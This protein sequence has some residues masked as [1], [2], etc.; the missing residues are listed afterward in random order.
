MYS[1]YALKVIQALG[2]MSVLEN[3]SLIGLVDS[4]HDA[5]SMQEAMNQIKEQFSDIFVGNYVYY[6]DGDLI[7]YC[8]IQYGFTH[9]RKLARQHL[10]YL[11]VYTVDNVEVYSSKSNVFLKEI[12]GVPFNTVL[13]EG[14]KVDTDR[15]E[16]LRMEQSE[17]P[18]V[19]PFNTNKEFVK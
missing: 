9:D 6:G 2:D 14:V 4:C 11:N 18:Y 7:C 3:L 8:H 13:F 15:V 16:R 17:N 1:V 5:S 12:P 19:F 10:Q